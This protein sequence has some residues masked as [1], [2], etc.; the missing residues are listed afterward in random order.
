MRKLLIFLGLVLLSVVAVPVL[1]AL[2]Q[3]DPWTC[4]YDFAEG[5]GGF[6]SYLDAIYEDG[7]W[8]SNDATFDPDGLIFYLVFPAATDVT[9]IQA[10]GFVAAFRGDADFEVYW[11]DG[12]PFS[13]EIVE[14][15]ITDAGGIA[16]DETDTT[17]YEDATGVWFGLTTTHPTSD[18]YYDFIELEGE[19]PSPCEDEVAFVKPL[20]SSDLDNEWNTIETYAAGFV[21]AQKTMLMY[22]DATGAKVHSAAAGTIT[23]IHKMQ[24]GDCISY[25]ASPIAVATAVGCS[26]SVHGWVFALHGTFVN[27]PVEVVTLETDNGYRL[28]YF[29]KNASNYIQEGQHVEADCW[30]G[31]TFILHTIEV[32]VG[33]GP[34]G[35]S[36]DAPGAGGVTMWSLQEA[37]VPIDGP[38][39]FSIEASGNAPCNQPE[40]YQDCMGDAPLNIASEWTV[41]GATWEEPGITLQPNGYVSQVMNLL[42][43]FNPTMKVLARGIGGS[44]TFRMQLGTTIQNETATPAETEFSIPPDEHAADLGGLYTVKVTNTSDIS[45]HLTYIC[46]QNTTDGE[47]EPTEPEEPPNNNNVCIFDNN[48]FTD[49]TTGWSVTSTDSGPGEIRVASGGTWSQ[50]VTVP[51]DTYDLT[52]VASVWSYNSFVSD[53]TETDDVTIEWDFPADTTYDGSQSKTF[54]QYAENNNLVVYRMTVVVG[55][56]TTGDFTMRVTLDSVPSGVRGI[57]IRSVCLGEE[58]GD[59]EGGD[60]GQPGDDGPFEVSCTSSTTP[61]GNS[62]GS[63]TGWLWGKFRSFFSCELMILL[64]SMY[65]LMQDSYRLF[66]WSI[67]YNQAVAVSSMNWVSLQLLPWLGGHLSNIAVGQVTNITSAEQCGNVFCLL[68]SLVT[69]F[70]DIITTLLNGIRDIM[71]DVIG[72]LF[73]LLSTALNAIINILQQIL[74]FVFS[75]LGTVVGLAVDIVELILLIIAK[76]ME[77]FDLML[78]LVQVLLTSWMNAAPIESDYLPSCQ[79]D[80][81]HVRCMIFYIAERTI[82]TEYGPAILTT[83]IAGLWMNIFFFVIYSV[84]AALMTLGVLS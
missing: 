13:N 15:D 18:S 21:S 26:I 83:L 46:V 36:T 62:F 32:G 34:F 59:G 63:W 22:S 80:Q 84:K 76:A 50:N 5:D 55:S 60:D 79:F 20:K 58:G 4:T 37:A 67:R 45:I 70:S 6:V 66:G 49:G 64:N 57:A 73:N 29:V 82:F 74:G 3:G 42:P 71:E 8:Q 2:A 10:T 77:L 12:T 52:I 54:G 38:D 68:Q 11:G 56:D 72:G 69:G 53:D 19:G 43:D 24:V 47:G 48:S 17:L 33:A 27:T 25:F 61:T 51:A 1:P 41:G 28:V 44:G 16:F 30:L 14:Y 31:E 35:V 75:V 81:T 40:G 65:D 78:Q 9:S 7:V 39:L 23:N